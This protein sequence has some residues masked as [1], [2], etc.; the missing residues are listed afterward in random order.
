MLKL[1]RD[2][3]KRNVSNAFAKHLQLHHPDREGDPSVFEVIVVRNLK[4][5]LDRPAFVGFRINLDSSEILVNSKS[6]YHQPAETRLPPPG[7]RNGER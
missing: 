2:I 4:K 5:P 6:E 1:R 3:E 7:K